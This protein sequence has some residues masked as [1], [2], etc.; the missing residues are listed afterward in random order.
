MVQLSQKDRCEFLS[1]LNRELLLVEQ[2]RK[3]CDKWEKRELCPSC[4]RGLNRFLT[5]LKKQ[6]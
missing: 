4:I 2:H 3:K 5:R 1:I 6:I